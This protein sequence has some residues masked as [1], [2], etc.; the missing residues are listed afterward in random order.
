MPPPIQ[1]WSA[2]VRAMTASL[3]GAT[4]PPLLIE[5]KLRPW[6]PVVVLQ[7]TLSPAPP[8]NVSSR[9][10]PATNRTQPKRKPLIRSS[11]SYLRPAQCAWNCHLFVSCISGQTVCAIANTVG[12]LPE[13]SAFP[14][15]GRKTD[16]SGS[17]PTSV[18]DEPAGPR[19]PSLPAPGFPARAPH[20]APRRCRASR[21]SPS[22]RCTSACRRNRSTGR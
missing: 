16:N 3:P 20:S 10:R 4:A 11:D 19:P 8:G 6:S 9:P 22:R 15:M 14:V 13:P 5:T 2:V 18:A 1:A 17:S 7:S 21:C 12:L